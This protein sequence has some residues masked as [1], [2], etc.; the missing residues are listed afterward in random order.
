LSGSV[1]TNPSTTP[2]ARDL[3]DAA[4]H[5]GRDAAA[6][7][8]FDNVDVV[9]EEHRTPARQ[10]RQLVHQDEPDAL[11]FL[12]RSNEERRV[13]DGLDMD[14]HGLPFHS[15]DARDVTRKNSRAATSHSA[16]VIV[17]N[18]CLGEVIHMANTD[19]RKGFQWRTASAT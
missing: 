4:Q 3:L 8:R 2:R 6:A 11:A 16:T 19:E 9:D 10:P 12:V 18:G 14:L 13:T 7:V 1:K 5:G 15:D 17:C